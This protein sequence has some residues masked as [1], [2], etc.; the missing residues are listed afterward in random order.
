MRRVLSETDE[1]VTTLTLDDHANR[2]ALGP[3]LIE[4]LL[5]AIDN[6]DADPDCRVIVLTNSGSVFCAGADLKANRVDGSGV[7]SGLDLFT[8]FRRSPKPFVG[9]INGHCV[10]GGMGLA[11]AMDISVAVDSAKFGFTEVRVGVAPAMISVLCLPKLRP[12]DAAAAFLRGNR[13]LAPEA[14]RIG[15]INAAVPIA[16]LDAEVQMIVDDLRRGGPQAIAAT[17]TLLSQVPGMSTDDAFEWTAKLS[18]DLFRQDEAREGMLAF[19][20]KRA[21]EWAADLEEP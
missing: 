18:A 1:G 2:N 4:Q 17:K 13:F 3:E 11:A 20:E 7:P 9:R 8:R 5:A 12:A 14:A 6:A 10:A 21:P 19:R 16:D 15:L